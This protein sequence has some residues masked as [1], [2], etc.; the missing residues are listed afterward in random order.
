MRI[1]EI[2]KKHDCSS[3]EVKTILDELKIPYKSHSSTIDED[4]L[5]KV[6][7]RLV[8]F[9]HKKPP[10]SGQVHKTDKPEAEPAES[11]S[12]EA[13]KTKGKSVKEKKISHK[14]DS[15]LSHQKKK[16]SHP[17]ERIKEIPEKKPEDKKD[18]KKEE[19][20]KPHPVQ[21]ESLEEP[22]PPPLPDTDD[23]KEDY[24]SYEEA[25]EE[26]FLKRKIPKSDRV[27]S[28]PKQ[29]E[30]WDKDQREE[31]AVPRAEEVKLI[32]PTG[33]VTVPD[34]LTVKELSEVIG[35]PASEIIKKLF[36]LGM[37]A[38]I[39]QQLDKDTLLIVA[40]EFKIDLEVKDVEITSEVAEPITEEL[41]SKEEDTL[42][43]RPPVITIMGHVDHGKTTLLDYIRKS[44]IVEQE[45]GGITQHIGAYLV[46]HDNKKICF[47]DTPG[48]SAFTA[49]RAMG[50]N[51]T[52]TVILVISAV[53]GIQPQTV[54]CINHA[55]EAEVP[56]IVAINKIDMEGA[57]VDRVKGQLAEM[58][59]TPEDWGG[60][61]LCAS[62]SALK[63]IG[64]DE[65][66]NAVNLQTELLELKA[67]PKGKPL[68][69]VIESC[70]TDHMGPLVT[71][72]VKN[73]EFKVG[74][75]VAC[76]HVYGKIRRMEDDRGNSVPTASPSVPVRIFGFSSVPDTA[77]RVRVFPSE[78]DARESARVEAEN[79]R[80]NALKKKET[81]TL[82]NLYSTI[83]A[84]SKKEL[85]AILKADVIGS[86][87][88][89]NSLFAGLPT[90]KVKLKIIH[91]ATGPVS[92]SDVMLAHAYHAIILAF[93]TKTTPS[94]AQLIKKHEVKIKEYGIIYQVLDD[95]KKY[96]EGLLDWEYVEATL[97]TC[98]VKKVFKIGKIGLVAGC[99]VTQGKVTKDAQCR[100]KRNGELLDLT[101]KVASLR[102][103]KD[104]ASEVKMGGECGI[105]LDGFTDIQEGDILEFHQMQKVESAL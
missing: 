96:M 70:Q 8:K 16:P 68:G 23:F 40:D 89:L 1:Y 53:E 86:I 90:E 98:E 78:K 9:L 6:E 49:M 101:C 74:D 32:R 97:G 52:D 30:T 29:S 88:A 82:D 34:G 69:I 102:H 48:H 13:H 103:Y 100:I 24:E 2:A 72:L 93:R 7:N 62:I 95:V 19:P 60:D 26:K 28:T 25:Y 87:T 80:H 12:S 59:L 63:G 67:N 91:S 64:I 77:A 81:I 76:G 57:N 71:V 17:Q 66:L 104:E 43:V 42:E 44:K 46:E 55:K 99:L 75:A 79:R 47:L 61:T 83:Q 14:T 18:K 20:L 94:A 37:I 36:L 3:N 50:A 84:E 22:I 54:E 105:S 92:D 85:K 33:K 21:P 5:P 15:D 10:S 31:E 4:V 27:K 35:I 39:N 38:S 45:S 73:G 65:L 56:I 41:F 11:V 58:S 51:V